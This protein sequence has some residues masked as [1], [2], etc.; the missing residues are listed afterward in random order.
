MFDKSIIEFPYPNGAA[1]QAALDNPL[2]EA[3]TAEGKTYR[4][5]VNAKLE[6]SP[7]IVLSPNDE[8][9]RQRWLDIDNGGAQ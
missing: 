2:Y 3:D 6:A 7:N 9:R 8:R 4:A 5:S 1:F